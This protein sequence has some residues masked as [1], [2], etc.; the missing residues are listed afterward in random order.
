[1]WNQILLYV[2][3][4]KIKWIANLKGNYNFATN[5][6]STEKVRNKTVEEVR[7]KMQPYFFPSYPKFN[8]N[9]IRIRKGW[10]RGLGVGRGFDF[11]IQSIFWNNFSQAKVCWNNQNTL[12]PKISIWHLG[13]LTMQKLIN[14]ALEIL[15][16][17]KVVKPTIFLMKF[18]T[19]QA[20]CEWG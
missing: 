15:K 16:M 17:F 5:V 14:I 18:D 7:R 4:I 11:T 9:Y 19:K 12:Q 8:P 20:W 1:M 2:K 13:V 10:E 3:S 6:I